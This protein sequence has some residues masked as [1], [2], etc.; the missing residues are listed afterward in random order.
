MRGV[1]AM[2]SRI[3]RVVYVRRGEDASEQPSTDK[4]AFY[5]LFIEKGCSN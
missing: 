1:V 2:T 3:A 4:L 5:L